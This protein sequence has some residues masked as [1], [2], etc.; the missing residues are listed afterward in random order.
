V[1]RLA[2]AF[3]GLVLGVVALGPSLGPGFTLR[4]DMVFVP[5]PPVAVAAGGFPRAM[6]SD[7]VVAL[8][9]HVLPAQ[10]VQKLILLGLFVLAASGAAALAPS[11]RTGVRL[12]VAAFYVWNAY[13]AQRLLLG[14]WAL[15]LGFAG[16]PWAARA[17]ARG[18]PWRLALA[19]IPAAVG[20]FQAMLVS[21]LTVISIR[22]V[23]STRPVTSTRAATATRAAGPVPRLR[24]LVEAV[25]V[26]VVLSLPWLVPAWAAQAVTDPGGVDAFA[27]R[28]D[29]PYGTVG[30]L[31][32]AGGIWNAEAG[33]PGQ[34][35]WLPAALRLVAGVAAIAAFAWTGA[36]G[37][38]G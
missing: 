14:Q 24:G 21:A 22:A 19:L 7:L 36:G 25:L 26:L 16:L 8:L 38:G 2:P 13:L 35:V 18:G 15:L 23:T 3:L 30:S 4:Y 11:R 20:G 32:A 31:L 33:V 6:P 34:G 9:A 1:W 17:A 10:I 5:D 27:A 29:G 37:A 28:A 12:A